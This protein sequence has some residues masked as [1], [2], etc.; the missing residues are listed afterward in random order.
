MFWRMI[1]IQYAA[2]FA[3]LLVVGAVFFL[4]AVSAG[5]A[6]AVALFGLGAYA[7]LAGPARPAFMHWACLAFPGP[8]GT[9]GAGLLHALE[10][11]STAFIDP[12][13]NKSVWRA[14]K[15][16]WMVES[17]YLL[18]HPQGQSR[19]RALALGRGLEVPAPTR[20]AARPR[21]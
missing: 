9:P 13:L 8:H 2:W 7:V 10:R 21:L 15:R 14:P 1:K 16:L 12:G 18:L 5:P 3:A 17:A 20:A 6:P 4:L 11:E 19:L